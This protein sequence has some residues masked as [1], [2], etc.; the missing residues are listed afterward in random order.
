MKICISQLVEACD[1]S[2][3]KIIQLDDLI[4]NLKSKALVSI[5]EFDE[6]QEE[7][8][9]TISSLYGKEFLEKF[10]EICNSSEYLDNL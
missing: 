3:R 1:K 7:F 2:M 10:F 6:I 9:N 4:E 8:Y 5:D